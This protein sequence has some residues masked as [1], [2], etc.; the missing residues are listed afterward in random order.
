MVLFCTDRI[1]IDVAGILSVLSLIIF[2]ILT[3]SEAFS[4]F[5]S[6]PAL[7]VAFVFVVACGLTQT[8]ALESLAHF[9]EKHSGTS[10]FKVNI[11]IMTGVA[12]FSAF[13]HHLMVTAL[14]LPVAMKVCEKNKI[15]ASR[16]LIPMATA[17]SL[18]TTLTL[19]GAPAF[20]VMNNIT[21]RAGGEAF[22]LFSVAPIGIVLILSSFILILLLKWLLPRHTG[23]NFNESLLQ[24]NNVHTELVVLEKSKWNGQELEILKEA[25][26]DQFTVLELKKR[27]TEDVPLGSNPLLEV[28]DTLRV[29]MKANELISIKNEHGLQLKALNKYIDYIGEGLSVDE[30]ETC[31]VQ[32]IVA[33]RSTY[34][35]RS[36]AENDFLKKFGMLVVGLWRKDAWISEEMSR[37]KIREGDLIIFWGLTDRLRRLYM[38][39]NFLTISLLKTQPF[40]RHKKTTAIIILLV[41][42]MLSVTKVFDPL[43]SFA[44]GALLMV[45][46]G[47]ITPNQAVKSVD[48]K[49][50]IL[51]ASVIPLGIAMDKTKLSAF[52]AE[53]VSSLIGSY[54]EISILIIFFTAAALLTQLLSDAATTVLL[55]PI[56]YF[57]ANSMSVSPKAAIVC[58]TMG[59]VASFLTPIGHHGNLLVLS[60]GRYKFTDFL[61]IGLPL[62][63]MICVETAY[64]ARYLFPKH[65]T[66]A[67][68]TVTPKSETAKILSHE[69]PT[70]FFYTS[71]K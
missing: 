2:G 13:T 67:I 60:P 7:L 22:G 58:V 63:L 42:I 10:E 3:P 64:V 8:G 28:G 33:N 51:I 50:Y 14:V 31:M 44:I 56:A 66:S 57:S 39:N 36:V 6:E 29:K 62:T 48:S 15:P 46:S 52:M 5:S 43:V 17:A 18:G 4:G 47:C 68:K 49:I 12:L 24:I 71:R 65:K 45:L 53:H 32:A 38:D 23:S 40:N 69:I 26:K 11:I 59:A 70:N 27:V 20:L 21:K 35:G 41:S 19:V 25:T 9:L 1:R 30:E 34:I 37:E 16:V 61:K 55:G 54:S